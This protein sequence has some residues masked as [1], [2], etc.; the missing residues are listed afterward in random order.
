MVTISVTLFWT[1]GLA[2][3][4]EIMVIT[5]VAT[6]IIPAQSGQTLLSLLKWILLF[7]SQSTSSS[8]SWSACWETRWWWWWWRWWWW[9]WW[10]CWPVGA[11]LR[12]LWWAAWRRLVVSAD[13]AFLAWGSLWWRRRWQLWQKLWWWV[14]HIQLPVPV[15]SHY[16][17]LKTSMKVIMNYIVQVFRVLS[18]CL[19]FLLQLICWPRYLNFYTIF[20]DN[21]SKNDW[22]PSCC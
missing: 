9:W 5:R 1:W 13:T 7:P 8:W 19:G 18:Q 20:F 10:W 12:P 21:C 11:A 14:T 16:W 6:V 22:F 17:K 2:G 4:S 3:F 15:L